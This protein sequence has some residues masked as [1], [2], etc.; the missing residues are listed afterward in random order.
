MRKDDMKAVLL[1]AIAIGI[2]VLF[3]MIRYKIATSE[4]PF[5]V[6][7]LLLQK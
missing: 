7:F 4:L 2:L 5:W 6:K 1:F 3:F